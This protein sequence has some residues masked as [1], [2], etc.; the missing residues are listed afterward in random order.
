MSHSEENIICPNCGFRASQNYC[1]QCGQETHLHKETFWGLVMHFIGHYFHYDSKFWQ[2]MKALWFSPG[3]LTLAYMN[4]KRM[5]YIPPV[6]LYIFISAVYFLLALSLRSEH[7]AIKKSTGQNKKGIVQ[8]TSAKKDDGIIYTYKKDTADKSAATEFIEKKIA[9][10]ESEHGDTKKYFQEKLNHDFPKL[11]F[12]MIPLMAVLLKLLFARRKPFQFIDHVIFS[13]H[14]QTFFFSVIL[15][16]LIRINDTVD[17]ITDLLLAVIVSW[18]MVRAMKN[19]YK[20]G[21]IRS[22][23]NTIALVLGYG[24]FFGIIITAYFLITLAL[25]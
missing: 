7:L 2:T 18:Y 4:K 5:R 20:I 21:N 25:V 14:Y 16:R 9:L 13:L 24:F 22:I 11:F 19:V 17:S 12:L 10:I 15:L 23:L 6:S 8:V 3:K 1:A